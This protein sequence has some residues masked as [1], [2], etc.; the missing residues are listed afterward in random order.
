MVD[1]RSKSIAEYAVRRWLLNQGFA[2][3]CFTLTVDGNRGTL[4]DKNGDTLV[5]VYD[6]RTKSVHVQED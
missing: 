1:K 3:D 4:K 5:L 2:M 6:G